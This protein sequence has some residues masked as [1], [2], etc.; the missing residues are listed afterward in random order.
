MEL[1]SENVDKIFKS[2]LFE[3]K[4]E[5]NDPKFVEGIQMKVGFNP[6]KIKASKDDI[7]SMI[8][9]LPENFKIDKGGGWS[10]LN[11]CVDKNEV[12]WT[13]MHTVVEQL[14]CLGLAT[15]KLFYVAPR[16]MWEV[17]AGGMPY[18]AINED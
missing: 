8:D 3:K 13:G 2:C 1:T 4:E 18:I 14:L 16:E 17:F 15:G 7:N 6:A 5:V 11:M 12:Q 10:F 9:E